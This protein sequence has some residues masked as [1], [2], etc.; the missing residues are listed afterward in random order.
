MNNGKDDASIIKFMALLGRLRNAFD[1]EPTGLKKL[2][3]EDDDLRRLCVELDSTAS[4]FVIME[5]SHRQVFAA[6]VDPKFIATWREYEKRYAAI[7]QDIG[8]ADMFGIFERSDSSFDF[9]DSNRRQDLEFKWKNADELA[10]ENARTIVAVLEFA[11]EQVTDEYRD[12][13]EEFVNEITDGIW[14]W[15]NLCHTTGLDIRGTLRRRQLVPFVLIPRH[16]SQ[17]HGEPEKLSLFTHLRQAHD[18]F[19]LGVPF[20]ALALMRAILEIT[21]KIH[22]AAEGKDLEDR[23]NNCRGLPSGA[24]REALHRL[25]KLANDILHFNSN[26]VRLP[27]DV[28][29]ELLTFLYVLRALI[30]RAPARIP[31]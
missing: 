18:A 22:Y 16:V 26:R 8:L 11:K 7:L 30:E 13:P 21:L 9:P 2:V 24:S 17:H 4:F 6:P 27:K 28:E 12:F 14:C 25:R 10:L 5:Q 20:A 15:N 3:M 31:K 1:D 29:K 19:I 23:I